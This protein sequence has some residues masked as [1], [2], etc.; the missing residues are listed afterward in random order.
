MDRTKLTP[1]PLTYLWFDFHYECKQ[2]GEWNNLGKLVSQVDD[3]FRSQK[4]FAKSSTGQV[5]SWQVGVIR[6]NC[7]DNLDLTNV[8]QSRDGLLCSSWIRLTRWISMA[9][10]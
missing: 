4:F 10:A 9:L 3:I 2:K 7:M 1:S 8:M 6:T 5:T